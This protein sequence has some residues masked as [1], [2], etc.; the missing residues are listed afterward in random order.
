MTTSFSEMRVENAHVLGG[1]GQKRGGENSHYNLRSDHA[2]QAREAE[3]E[4]LECVLVGRCQAVS[5]QG[6]KC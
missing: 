2:Q 4:G 1:E 3:K 6:K 5:Y